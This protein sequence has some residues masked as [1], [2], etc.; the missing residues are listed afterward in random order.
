MTYPQDN[1][2]RPLNDQKGWALCVQPPPQTLNIPNYFGIP[3][4]VRSEII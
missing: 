2:L 1:Y 3:D 4:V